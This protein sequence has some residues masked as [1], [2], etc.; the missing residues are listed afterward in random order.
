MRSISVLLCFLV[1]LIHTP[2]VAA[3]RLIESKALTLCQDSSNFTATYF[4]VRYTP[5]NNSLLIGFDGVSSISGYVEATI[6]LD[7]YGYT[8][9]RQTF[10]PCDMDLEGLCPMN[11][12]PMNIRDAPITIGDDVASQIPGT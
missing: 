2:L 1:A 9:V 7:A 6:V 8:A 10:N 5:N 3:E 4:H 11:T 12:G